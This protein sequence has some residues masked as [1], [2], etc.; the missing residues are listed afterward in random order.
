[1][2]PSISVLCV[3]D[4]ADIRDLYRQL[5]D[6]EPD[7]R[8]VGTLEGAEGLV[9][10]VVRTEPDVVLLDLT[11]PGPDPLSA[12]EELS[13]RRPETRVLLFSGYD[14]A[15]TADAAL[16]AGAWGLVSKHGDSDRVLAAIRAVAGGEIVLS[17][18]G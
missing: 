4:S 12:V 18:R 15:E 3:D 2:P 1:M 7:L 13:R 5:I 14:D 8:C 6:A 16:D 9:E 17:H 10:E 11:M